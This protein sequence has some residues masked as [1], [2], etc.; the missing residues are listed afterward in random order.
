MIRAGKHGGGGDDRGGGK[1]GGD[2]G[3]DAVAESSCVGVRRKAKGA[4]EQYR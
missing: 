2:D 1:S 3:E 4:G